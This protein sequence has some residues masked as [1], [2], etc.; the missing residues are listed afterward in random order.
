MMLHRSVPQFVLWHYRQALAL[1]AIAVAVSTAM[2]IVGLAL[3]PRWLVALTAAGLGSTVTT[4][5]WGIRSIVKSYSETYN[6]LANN[7]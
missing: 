7:F 3:G 5:A 1:H 6:S 4:A 2:L